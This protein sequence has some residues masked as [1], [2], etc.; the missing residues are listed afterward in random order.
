MALPISEIRPNTNLEREIFPK[1][2]TSEAQQ[3]DLFTPPH[4]KQMRFVKNN[5][6]DPFGQKDEK[7][8]FITENVGEEEKV[9]KELQS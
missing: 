2:L 9:I 1:E 4:H 3:K 8:F 5:A 7:Q 6:D